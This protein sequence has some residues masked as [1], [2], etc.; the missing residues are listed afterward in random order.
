MGVF[1]EMPTL[2]LF[3][4]GKT[5]TPAIPSDG[6]GVNGPLRKF[7]VPI[8]LSTA[9][10]LTYTIA[11]LLSGYILRDPTADA[12]NDVFPTATKIVNG[13]GPSVVVGSYIDFWIKNSATSG[14]TKDLIPIA[15][16]GITLSPSAAE[17]AKLQ[18]AVYRAMVTNVDTPAV[19]IYCLG[20]LAVPTGS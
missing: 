2:G 11:Q 16:A 10:D 13:L 14:G 8:T 1:T 4:W 17:I 3:P 20:I 9:S 6:F 15:G 7:G 18:T 5:S 19:T 12:R